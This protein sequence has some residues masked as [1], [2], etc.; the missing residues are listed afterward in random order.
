M[1]VTLVL[2]NL[3]QEYTL[4]YFYG[5][6]RGLSLQKISWFFSQLNPYIPPWLQKRF[7]LMVLRLLENRLVNQK[8]EPVY[9]CPQ[10]KL[11][12]RFLS[13]PLQVEGSYPFPTKCF[14]NLFFPSREWED[15]GAENMTKIKLAS[16]LVTS[17]DKSHYLQALHFRFLFCCAI[18]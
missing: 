11:S 9:S 12:P 7:K 1:L 6:L 16:V 13:S 2:Q 3:I 8:I 17:F 15:Y 4:L 5:L 10:A 14:Q 18:I